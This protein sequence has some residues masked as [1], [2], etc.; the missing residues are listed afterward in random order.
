MEIYQD[1]W[2]AGEK[3]IEGVR[4]CESRYEAIRKVAAQYNRPITVL[5]IGANMGYFSFRLAEEFDGTFVMVEGG[6]A[7]SNNLQRLCVQNDNDKVVLLPVRFNLK[8]LKA[9]GSFEHF[10]IVIACSVIHH[11]GEDYNEVLKAIV[12]LGDDIVIEHPVVGERA[13]NQDRI[14]SKG[15]DFSQYNHELIAET[16]THT[17][18]QADKR[19]MY[20]IKSKK[21]ELKVNYFTTEAKVFSSRYRPIKIISS[22]DKKLFECTRKKERRPW[23]HGINFMTF[24]GYHGNF[25][26]KNM[27]IKSIEDMQISEKANDV[28]PWNFI[29]SG[30]NLEIIDAYDENRECNPQLEFK[31][32]IYLLKDGYFDNPSNFTGSKCQGYHEMLDRLNI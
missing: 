9:L 24:L 11:F 22:K 28:R 7:E 4:I 16:A 26:T 6:A 15:L 13:C 32:M 5:D 3:K 31:K 27:L 1:I 23:I 18:T 25:P 30:H 17:N 8:D 20:H 2:V 19:K 12:D 21:E 29:L 14:E 10:D